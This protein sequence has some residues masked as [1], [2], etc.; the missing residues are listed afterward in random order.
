MENAVVNSA[1]FSAK[2]EEGKSRNI[3]AGVKEQGFFVL[4][5]YKC[6]L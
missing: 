2:E 5:D 4:R 1:I 3:R 6:T